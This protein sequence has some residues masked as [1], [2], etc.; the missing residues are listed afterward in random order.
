MFKI[1]NEETKTT[2]IDLSPNEVIKN[3]VLSVDRIM[4]EDSLNISF[5]YQTLQVNGLSNYEY[6]FRLRI[7]AIWNIF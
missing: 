6:I 5:L 3:P 2:S 7:K 1:N 4:E